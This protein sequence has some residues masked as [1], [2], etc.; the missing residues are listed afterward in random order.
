MNGRYMY[1]R[2]IYLYRYL[3]PTPSNFITMLHRYRKKISK[4]QY[5]SANAFMQ[6][7]DL[8]IVKY[9]HTHTSQA[10]GNR[11]V[12]FILINESKYIIRIYIYI[13]TKC[14]M[15]EW[16]ARST[17]ENEYT[18]R[19]IFF[20]FGFSRLRNRDSLLLYIIYKLNTL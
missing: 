11:N 10:S 13:D 16:K 3:Q 9:T 4:I 12:F 7:R 17:D 15:Y 18:F 2:Q 8:K 19:L 14:F 5:S 1:V 20:F 6:I